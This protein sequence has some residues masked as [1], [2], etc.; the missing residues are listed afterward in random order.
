[1]FVLKGHLK[2]QLCMNTAS[3]QEN[4][5]GS[6]TE[7]V[8]RFV[9][10]EVIE[11]RLHPGDIIDRKK[12]AKELG[13]SVAPVGRAITKL[14]REGFVEVL[15]RRLTRVRSIRE[16]DFRAN[17]LLRT[18][19]ECQAARVYCGKPVQR[20]RKYLLKLAG[21]VDA[22]DSGAEDRIE[23]WENE[24]AFHRAL[25][26]LAES[27]ALSAEYERVM[28]LG[29]FVLV[30]TFKFNSPFPQD[31]LGGW[32][33]QLVEGLQTDDADEAE[34]LLREHLEYGRT[35]FLRKT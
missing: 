35:S 21:R 1:M 31:P 11:Q 13:T 18:A 3:Q 7:Q 19:L 10:R 24:I 25:V 2:Y 17:I 12:L 9:L 8:Y 5:D 32:H 16:E 23:Y 14:E 20:K 29:L 26:D 4:T 6:L 33:A 30:G 28:N 15:P 34:A 27:P 22:A